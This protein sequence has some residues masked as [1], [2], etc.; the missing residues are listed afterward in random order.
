[1]TKVIEP[2][3]T[4]KACF[5]AGTLVHTNQGLVPI[6]DV[7]VGDMVLSSPELGDGAVREYKRVINIFRSESEEIWQL[8]VTFFKMIDGEYGGVREF[9]Y[10]TKNHPVYLV[11]SEFNESKS[12]HWIPAH[13][14][15]AGDRILLATFESNGDDEVTIVKP[16]EKISDNAGYCER[17]DAPFDFNSFVEFFEDGTYETINHWT[18]DGY[19]QRDLFK[20]NFRNFDNSKD[21]GLEYSFDHRTFPSQNLKKTVFNFEV[22][23]FHTY[24]VGELGLW[25]HH[26]SGY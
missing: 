26:N 4:N 2:Q 24:F 5:V 15:Y 9:I 17:Q 13:E 7:Q 25:V 21:E 19:F 23:D 1:M 18:I 20:G 6:Q 8:G 11:Y 22:E 16:I 12:G 3:M 10:L 14:L